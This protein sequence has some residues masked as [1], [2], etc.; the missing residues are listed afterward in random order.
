MRTVGPGGGGFTLI[1]LLVV[2][3]IIGVL[4]GILI[5]GFMIARRQVKISQTRTYIQQLSLACSNYS[6]AFGDLPPSTLQDCGLNTNRTND[7]VE[8][9]VACLSTTRMDGPYFD[10]EDEFLMNYDGDKVRDFNQSVF[11]TGL[12]FEVVD[13]WGN[14]YIYFHN[15][16][17]DRPAVAG[18]YKIIFPKRKIVHAAPA[19]SKKKGVYYGLDSF[20]LWSVGPNGENENGGGDDIPSWEAH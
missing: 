9:L 14:P 1:E 5:P 20:Q 11:K 16:D 18:R 8:S 17:Y 3:A 4:M 6:G 19:K 10:F 13:P 2:M 7:G 15:R 12:A